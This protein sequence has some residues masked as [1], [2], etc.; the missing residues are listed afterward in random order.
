M[1][2][3]SRVG[4]RDQICLFLRRIAGLCNE[5]AGKSGPFLPLA[6]QIS[7]KSDRLLGSVDV[8][9][10]T[11]FGAIRDEKQGVQRV[12]QSSHLQGAGRA[13][14]PLKRHYLT[15]ASGLRHGFVP[16]VHQTLRAGR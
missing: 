12:V 15:H 5:K 8:S 3:V 14:K 4:K 16:E 6:Q 2:V 7:L 11:A 10:T 13:C 1:I 9:F